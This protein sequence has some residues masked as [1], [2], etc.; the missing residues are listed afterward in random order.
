PADLPRHGDGLGP[1]RDDRR[2][3][4]RARA[5]ARAPGAADGGAAAARAG[6]LTR[7]GIPA[8]RKRWAGRTA[9]VTLCHLG[10]WHRRVTGSRAQLG[11]ARVRAP[12]SAAVAGGARSGRQSEP[13]DR[14]DQSPPRRRGGAARAPAAELP[15]RSRP[16]PPAAPVEEAADD[17][18]RPRRHRVP[19]PALRRAA[20][21]RER[22][23]RRPPAAVS[24]SPVKASDTVSLALRGDR[25]PEVC[26]TRPR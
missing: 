8:P 25:G 9:L 12:D 16:R 21:P 22:D 26:D 4:G 14:R 13:A 11:R 5:G 20:R 24:V 7:P 17:D 19:R 15:A 6:A 18:Q 1:L 10:I 2:R 23:R 3:L